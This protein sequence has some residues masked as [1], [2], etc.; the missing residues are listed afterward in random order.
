MICQ[1]PDSGHGL[2]EE[3]TGKV[4]GTIVAFLSDQVLTYED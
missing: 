3:S 2:L 1:V 4:V